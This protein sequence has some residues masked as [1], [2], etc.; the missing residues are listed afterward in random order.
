MVGGGAHCKATVKVPVVIHV[1]G[2]YIG[3]FLFFSLPDDM[4]I[5]DNR[6]H[7]LLNP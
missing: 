3:V 2:L 7:L 5:G 4:L 6:L 1:R